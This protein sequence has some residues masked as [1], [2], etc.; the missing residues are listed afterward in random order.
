LK[1]RGETQ[2]D[3]VKRGREKPFQGE[4][5]K[6]QRRSGAGASNGPKR[7][8]NHLK[9]NVNRG[10]PEKD[11]IGPLSPREHLGGRSPVNKIQSFNSSKEA[12]EGIPPN[13]KHPE[14]DGVQNLLREVADARREVAW[15]LPLKRTAERPQR[16]RW[17]GRRS[18]TD[19]SVGS[20]G[21][22]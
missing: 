1:N 4:G 17:G 20:D 3:E 16:V 11:R 9:R 14:H 6:R 8:P 12:K 2:G 15:Q 10:K 21:E 22:I 19:N 18:L 5:K 7:T 13:T